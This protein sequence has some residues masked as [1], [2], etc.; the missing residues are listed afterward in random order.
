MF[1]PLIRLEKVIFFLH[2]ITLSSSTGPG[3]KVRDIGVPKCNGKSGH[4]LEELEDK[5]PNIIIKCE[6]DLEFFILRYHYDNSITSWK[7]DRTTEPQDVK[8]N[9]SLLKFH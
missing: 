6:F 3:G 1:M 5:S 7:A 4:W 9:C 2:E 8:P